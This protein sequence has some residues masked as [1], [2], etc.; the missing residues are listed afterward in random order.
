VPHERLSG[1]RLTAKQ[2]AGLGAK[3][4]WRARKHKQI[5][6]FSILADLVALVASVPDRAA[7]KFR[8]WGRHELLPRRFLLLLLYCKRV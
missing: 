6:G 1:G 5:G 3:N 2:G 4:P 8:Q 7:A